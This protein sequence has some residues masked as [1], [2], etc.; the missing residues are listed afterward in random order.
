MTTGSTS[1]NGHVVALLD[2]YRTGE[3]SDEQRRQVEVHLEVC[4][5][6]MAA[7]TDLAAFAA[8]VEKGYD[9]ER[10]LA[11]GSEPDWARVRQEIVARTSAKRAASRRGWL[12]RH[13]PQTAAAV[14]AVLAVVIVVQQGVRGPE[15]VSRALR[16]TQESER[17]EVDGPETPPPVGETRSSEEGELGALESATE[18]LERSADESELH[19]LENMRRGAR[20]EEI[21]RDA[22]LA[23]PD[24]RARELKDGAAVITGGRAADPNE[25]RPGEADGFDEANRVDDLRENQI[26]ADREIGVGGEIEHAAEP[27][28]EV[29]EDQAVQ[30]KPDAAAPPRPDEEEVLEDG[31]YKQKRAAGQDA[32]VA[33]GDDLDVAD[34][35]EVQIEVDPEAE[36]LS[37]FEMS[38]RYAITR[39]DTL[40]ANAAL[41]F[42]YD[43]LGAG[44]DL[45]L[46]DRERAQA[47]ADSLASLLARR[48]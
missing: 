34:K 26:A 8:T 22:R 20:N 48:P 46:P 16:P 27:K 2:Q 14:V 12:A 45:E 47:L 7:L 37:R 9:V 17:A 11:A 15:D 13:V 24:E 5:D 38:A 21:D 42:W 35:L 39:S 29:F 25:A 28:R 43:S 1:G 30:E 41:N 44:A 31:Y 36:P 19:Q 10:A 32:K 4:G 23:A 33:E 3:L 40:A 6:C 18:T